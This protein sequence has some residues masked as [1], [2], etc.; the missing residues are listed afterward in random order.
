MINE[1]KMVQFG[2]GNIGRSFIGQ[3]FARAGYE[4]VFVDVVDEVV[5]A[6]NE[7]RSYTVEVRDRN[8][9]TLLI[10][11]VRAVHG[12]NKDAVVAELA[13]C[14]LC[15]TAVGPKALVAI[16]RALAAG[17]LART[18]RGLPPLDVI[19]CENLRDAASFMAEGLA[20]NLPEGFPLAERVGLVETS[21]G[22]MVPIMPDEVRRQDP[23]L[24]YAEAYNTLICD[25]TAFLNPVP[26]V[27]GL[28][29]RQNMT[30][31]VDRKSFVH[32][33]GHALCAYFAHL[34]APELVYTWQAVEHPTV[35]PATRAGMWESARALIARY[36]GEFDE[37]H[38][39]AHIEDLLSRFCNQALGDT[40]YRV[41]RDISRKL[42]REDRVIGPLLLEIEQCGAP[43]PMTALCAAAGMQFRALDE[44][45]QP[46]GPDIEF[47][48]NVYSRG[49]EFVL[50]ETCGLDCTREPDRT[51][52]KAVLS[53]HADLLERL[54]SGASIFG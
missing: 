28:D 46:F 12:A 7:R 44:H 23:L 50:S 30:A 8:P 6:L 14:R 33:F 29:A 37:A 2:A 35:G 3:L 48:E 10:E 32:N 54:A 13:D 21:I 20:S 47:A 40:I 1:R 42:S 11:N 41:G 52:C 9:E 5:N 34:E 51:A 39:D 22:K 36:P 17:I 16:Q 25:R 4:V 18:E 53:A 27:P 49:P 15:A 31:Y 19:L 38:M 26:D 45:G 43:G 24:V